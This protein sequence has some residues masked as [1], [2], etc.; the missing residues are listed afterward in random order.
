MP[1]HNWS[2][3]S[4]LSLRGDLATI[5]PFFSLEDIENQVSV[6][7]IQGGR[8]V[9]LNPLPRQGPTAIRIPLED[10]KTRIPE[11]FTVVG[12]RNVSVI[13]RAGA[14]PILFEIGGSVVFADNS[15]FFA[16]GCY[17]GSGSKVTKE[18]APR[19]VE[20]IRYFGSKLENVFGFDATI[21]R[22]IE[23]QKVGR[24][25][26]IQVPDAVMEFIDDVLEGH[27]HGQNFPRYLNDPY[28]RRRGAGWDDSRATKRYWKFRQVE[29]PLYSF[30]SADHIACAAVLD[31]AT[32]YDS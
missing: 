20:G 15:T 17:Y 12:G 21:F 30:I 18:M 29:S 4:L 10:C 6:P 28:Y 8:A 14:P 2:D 19:V 9:R 32:P 11:G 7:S 25:L 16:Y 1:N 24:K 31:G 5:K 22:V 26:R 13:I 3:Y 23:A 27:T